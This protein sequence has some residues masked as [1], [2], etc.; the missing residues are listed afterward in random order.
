MY[1]L[2]I[3]DQVVG[4]CFFRLAN[5][6]PV[7]SEHYSVMEKIVPHVAQAVGRITDRAQLAN[8]VERLAQSNRDLENFAAVVAHDLSA[9][10][11]RIGSY[12]QLLQRET[13]EL[14]PKA[15]GYAQ[16]IA[17]QVNHL[18]E[19]LK[20]TLAYAHVTAS[21][22]GRSQRAGE[23]NRWTDGF[24]ATRDRSNDRDRRPAR[25]RGRSVTD[26]TGGAES[27]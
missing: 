8:H 17:S 15:R 16:T 14:P 24:G 25:G 27:G 2:E 23:R 3:G 20:D 21:T 9:P 4:V 10:V 19:L 13:G 11:R 18:S 7:T 22:G 5:D 1:P 6:E 12:L 26:P